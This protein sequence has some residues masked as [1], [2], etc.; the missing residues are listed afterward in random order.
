MHANFKQRSSKS[1][2]SEKAKIY[3]EVCDAETNPG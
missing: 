2:Y 1:D 3:N